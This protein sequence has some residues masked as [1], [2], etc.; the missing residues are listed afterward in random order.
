M[1]TPG[2]GAVPRGPAACRYESCHWSGGR[3]GRYG[4]TTLASGK[5][6]SDMRA[7]EIQGEH[8]AWS[9]YLTGPGDHETLLRVYGIGRARAAL[10]LRVFG[11]VDGFL[12]TPADVVAERTQGLIGA[13]LARTLQARARAVEARTD[14]RRV[15]VL[16]GQW[17]PPPRALEDVPQRVTAWARRAGS[18]L[19]AAVR[20]GWSACLGAVVALRAGSATDH[21]EHSVRAE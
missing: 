6:C 4:Q 11:S 8:P 14:W 15:A 12:S 9:Q 1:V 2:S 19:G 17:A 16:N 20:P 18:Q 3:H 7:D 21:Q 10:L 13:G 5:A